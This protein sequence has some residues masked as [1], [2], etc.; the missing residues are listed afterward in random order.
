MRPKYL[1]AVGLR[2]HPVLT[3]FAALTLVHPAYAQEPAAGAVSNNGELAEIVVTAQKRSESIKEIPIS[4][5]AIGSEA[6]STKQIANYD[7]LSRA[8]PGL[9]FASGGSE[10]L[11]NI[12]IRGVSSQSGSATVGVYLDDV[13]VTVTNFFHDG[14]TQP[15]LYD[16]DR[17]EVLRGPQGTLYGASSMGGTIRFVTKQ[18]DFGSYSVETAADLSGTLHAGVNTAE[19]L[20][21]NMPI[22][23][24]KL[25]LR[26]SAGYSYDS[27]YIDHYALTGKLENTGTNSEK[28]YSG[29]FSLK[30]AATDDLTITT[31]L[32]AQEVRSGDSSVFYP[33]L[34]IWNQDKEVQE[35]GR[36]EVVLPSLTIVED[37]GFADF[38]SVSGYFDRDYDR[39]QDGTFYN[40][41]GFAT[42]FLDPIYPSYK[43][44]NDSIIG[45]LASPVHYVSAYRQ[46]S[47]EFRLTS[48]P[49]AETGLP[50]KWVVGLYYSDQH[51]TNSNVEPIPGIN[52]AFQKIYGI[53]M[54]Q[55]LVETYYG[56]PGLSLFPKDN[57][58]TQ[59][60]KLDERQYAIYG[61]LDWDILPQLHATIGGRYLYARSAFETST[62]GFYSI[63][64]P[65]TYYNNERFYGFTPKFGL[66]YDVTPDTNIY[67]SATKGYRLGG[68]DQ[69]IPFGPTSIC[70]SDFNAIGVTSQ[71]KKFDSDTL[72][73]YELG[74]KSRMLNNTLSV[75]AAAY[76]I[77]WKKIQQLVYLPTCGFYYVSNV[78][79]AK[80]YGADFEIEY[81]VTP[82]LQLGLNGGITRAVLT[83]SN[84]P[85]TA[86]TGQ[87]VLNSPIYS[88]SVSAGYGWEVSTNWR[89]FA[90]A[91]YD[92][93]GHSYGSYMRSN[94]DY[95]DPSYGVFNMMVGVNSGRYQLS[96]Y[97]K[98]LFDNRTIIQEP[99]IN[100]VFTG[101]TV[102]PLTVGVSAKMY[103]E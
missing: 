35:P 75:N 15:K 79:D 56:A 48:H 19:S 74:T 60:Y 87:S 66:A 57:A 40:S 94:S 71:P 26:A 36:D 46:P 16:I 91:D 6:L 81:R 78:G 68:S 92:R 45:T 32:F 93:T 9:S 51:A 58:Y 13:S 29:R 52:S 23:D 61:Q 100:S 103:F 85:G 5:T 12:E 14:S 99:E 54:E 28:S 4:I 50:I 18:P 64:L 70:N 11:A 84:N 37:L 30:Y 8:V 72:W 33:A 53:P 59:T 41:A 25:A 77:D 82:D 67:A 34:G 73:S 76:Y 86:A 83:S 69:P 90:H 44:Q 22:V 43:Q 95:R 49:P 96:L 39:Q 31:S 10:G 24:G 27:G 20:S 62:F 3:A 65:P 63:G 47:Q 1:L 2:F 7:D 101:Y 55:S 98:N 42:I 17:V 97:G 88:L 38:T 80:S 21:V 102:R 89:G